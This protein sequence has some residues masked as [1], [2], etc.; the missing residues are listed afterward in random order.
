MHS[1]F[2]FERTSVFFLLF[3][4]GGSLHPSHDFKIREMERTKGREGSNGRLNQ[5]CGWIQEGRVSIVTVWL[6]QHCTGSCDFQTKFSEELFFLKEKNGIL[7]KHRRNFENQRQLKYI[8]KLPFGAN[9][10]IYC[11]IST[12]LLLTGCESE[13]F[14]LV[15]PAVCRTTGIFHHLPMVWVKKSSN[16]PSCFSLFSYPFLLSTPHPRSLPAPHRAN[17]HSIF[18]LGCVSVHRWL[19]L[20]KEAE[21]NVRGL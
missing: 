15:L 19:Y 7:S 12:A 8:L 16:S 3:F 1:H 11:V 9:I 14:S 5:N 20:V 18:I 17:W 6:T 13:L 10:D 4:L 21:E 2:P